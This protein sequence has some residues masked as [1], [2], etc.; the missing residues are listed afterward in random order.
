MTP[1]YKG[2]MTIRPVEDTIAGMRD[3]TIREIQKEHISAASKL[4]WYWTYIGSLDMAQQLGLIED[5]RRQELY[6]EI[7]PY[8]PDCEVTL[9][10][11]Q[12]QQA[13]EP[14]SSPQV[15]DGLPELC[16]SVLRNTGELICIKRGESGYYP[17]DW[18][19]GD[20][21]ANRELADYHNQRLGVTDAQR[22]AME[23]GSMFGWGCPGADP[24]TYEQEPFQM[25]GMKFE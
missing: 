6:R 14:P 23:A 2:E 21:A 1:E 19:T 15:A 13:E 24:K 4:A 8:K 3:E 5:S 7:A 16:F 25:G 10:E 12:S 20:P 11:A 9:K 18:D 17:S 22:K